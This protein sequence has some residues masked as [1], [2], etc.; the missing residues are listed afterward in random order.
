MGL[1]KH[2]DAL[3]V[4]VGGDEMMGEILENRNCDVGIDRRGVSRGTADIAHAAGAEKLEDLDL[5]AKV[6]GH[7]GGPHS[8]L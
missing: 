4:I 6:L 7:E 8:E 5:A 3:R 1:V 2:S